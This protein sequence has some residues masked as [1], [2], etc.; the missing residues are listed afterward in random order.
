M[1]YSQAMR[2]LDSLPVK[3][4]WTLEPTRELCSFSGVHP[5]SLKAV[6][7]A[8]T[9]GKGSAAAMIHSILRAAWYPTGLYTSPHLVRF[10]E[11]IEVDG[12]KISDRDVA[13]LATFLQPFIK[14]INAAGGEPVSYFEAATAMAFKHFTDC[15]V[16]FAVVEAGM[17]GRLDATNVVKPLVA[18]ITGVSLDH[19]A[20]LGE[21]VEK[22]AGEKAGIIKPGIPVVASCTGKALEVVERKC[23]KT[24]AELITVGSEDS[25]TGAADVVFKKIKADEKK[26][27]FGVKGVF[28]NHR[29][30]TALLGGFQAENAAAAFA[31]VKVLEGKGIGVG[32]AAVRRGLARV[33]WPGR[34]EIVSRKPL[35]VLDGAHN[36]AK[37]EALA[38]ALQEIFQRREKIMVLGIMADKDIPG[39]MRA[40]APAAE[41][42]IATR[43]RV[44]RAAPAGEIA[45]EAN[46]YCAAVEV[47]GDAKKALEKAVGE[48]GK[49]GRRSM[50]VVTGSLYLVGEAKERMGW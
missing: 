7:V 15:G 34:M 9:N 47:E 31:A 32:G 10:N 35:V 18:V 45:G 2:F 24:G 13:R 19:T 27:V 16:D 6:H 4:K 43:P 22:I 28:G 49:S 29:F 30:S 40:L 3:K 8:G 12:K 50:A 37:A 33:K 26:T 11:R 38:R 20:A 42:I 23:R 5:E 25:K 44:E 36:P 17:G 48:A 46:K 14:K 1:N 39:I 41:K 21:T